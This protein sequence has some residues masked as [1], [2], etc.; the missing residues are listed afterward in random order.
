MKKLFGKKEVNPNSD[1]IQKEINEMI[2]C[3]TPQTT[4]YLLVLH[5]N[6]Q[7]VFL[8]PCTLGATGL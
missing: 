3:K 5:K 4:S 6:T 2:V 8:L 1:A 7:Y